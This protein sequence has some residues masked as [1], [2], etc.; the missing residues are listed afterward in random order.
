MSAWMRG[1]F[2]DLP[3]DP[4]R[5]AAVDNQDLLGLDAHA[6]ALASFIKMCSTPM[7]ATFVR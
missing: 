3:I 6:E 5:A 7:S 1:G 2:P 4:R